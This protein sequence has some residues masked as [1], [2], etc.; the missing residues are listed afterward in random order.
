[1]YERLWGRT[2][3]LA[4]V[5]EAHKMTC[6]ALKCFDITT[7]LLRCIDGEL[8]IFMLSCLMKRYFA[9]WLL[10]CGLTFQEQITA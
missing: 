6:R 2:V 8:K 3:P 7:D 5:Y 4:Y 9:L 10:V 1:M